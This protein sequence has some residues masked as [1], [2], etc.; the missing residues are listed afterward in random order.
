MKDTGVRT[1]VCPICGQTYHGR[2]ALS[3]LDNVTEICP[4]C[5]TRQ[6]LESIGVE[7]EEREQILGII[8]T[9]TGNIEN[10]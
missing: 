1:A 8:H 7:P 9:H 5:G 3:R 10:G 4:D 2:P 6:A